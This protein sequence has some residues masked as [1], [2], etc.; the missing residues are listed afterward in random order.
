M[1]TDLEVPNSKR[2]RARSGLRPFII[3]LLAGA[4]LMFFFSGLIVKVALLAALI[5]LA[6]L[7]ARY[8]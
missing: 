5:G 2:E 8:L 3:G 1:E 4:A 6:L 7:L